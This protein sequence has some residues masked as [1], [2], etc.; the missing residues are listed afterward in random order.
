MTTNHNYWPKAT[1]TP[2][3]ACLNPTLAND[4]SI[5]KVIDPNGPYDPVAR[6]C[7]AAFLN[8]STSPP[9]TPNSI[10]SVAKA[11]AIWTSYV[12]NAGVFEPTAG[13]KWDGP[14][15]VAWIM[16]TYS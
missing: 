3:S 11:Q 12:N 15:I 1:N 10:L 14:K 8:A 6:H 9:L 16:T 7:L 2:F 5:K 4:P 13:I